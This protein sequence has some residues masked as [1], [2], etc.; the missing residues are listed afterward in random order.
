[1]VVNRKYNTELASNWEY[2]GLSTDTKPTIANGAKEI[3]PDM[4]IF[5]EMDTGEGY[6]YHKDTDSW[7]LIG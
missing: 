6:Y 4:S 7:G 5:V 3:P 2:F 1:M